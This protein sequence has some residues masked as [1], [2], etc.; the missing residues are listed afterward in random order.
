MDSLK[1]SVPGILKRYSC[2]QYSYAPGKFQSTQ[3][4]NGF[5][6]LHPFMYE[7]HIVL[8]VVIVVVKPSHDNDDIL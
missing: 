2:I 4:S 3:K 5:E 8:V 7:F 1:D 6:M